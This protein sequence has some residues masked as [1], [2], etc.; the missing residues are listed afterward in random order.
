MNVIHAIDLAR[1]YV[2]ESKRQGKTVAL[3]A[4]M[5]NL[6]TGHLALVK[7]AQTQAD[8]V[9]VSIFV[10]P[11]QFGPHEDFD[12]YPRTLDDDIKQLEGVDMVFAPDMAEIYPFGVEQST[13]VM[14]PEIA[15]VLEG[16]HRPGFFTGVASVVAKLFNILPVDIAVF[17]KKDYQQLLVISHMVADLN[18]PIKIVAV[19]TVREADGLAKSS[20]NGYLSDKERAL[21]P[22]LQQELQTAKNKVSQDVPVSE[23]VKSAKEALNALGFEVD[24]FA[25][26]DNR[27]L[28]GFSSSSKSVILVAAKLGKTRL[29][30]NLEV[31][32]ASNLEVVQQGLSKSCS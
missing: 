29:I 11:M 14:V 8:V 4:T 17:G 15:D 25:I 16:K 13:K 1:S 3:V 2:E 6:H 27:S 30:D 24:Y 7:E 5:G 28:Q 23:I 20:R 31:Q 18:F 19:E 21:A 26:V 9:V 32:Q 10:N 22:A 12:N